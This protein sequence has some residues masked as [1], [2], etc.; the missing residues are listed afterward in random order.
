MPQGLSA[1]RFVLRDADSGDRLAARSE[2]ARTPVASL[3]KLLTALLVI[4]SPLDGD[5]EI[6]P[7]DIDLPAHF[8]PAVAGLCV[9]QSY[10][11]RDL[12][13]AMLV[14]S[15][16]DAAM[17]L[18]RAHSGSADAFAAAMTAFAQSLGMHDSRFVN[19]HGLP[20]EGQYSTAAD[21]ARLAL[22][23]DRS[24]ALRAIVR[25]PEM[26]IAHADGTATRLASTNRLLATLPGCDGMKTG[27]TR[28]SGYC[29]VASA[30][31]AA[32]RR[33]AIVLG[34]TRENVWE[35]ARLLLGC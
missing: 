15:A 5:I 35:D 19:P 29:L 1:G 28:A 7:E 33:T 3:Q 22:A 17:A 30:D 20:A 34:A 12:L 9:G 26:T 27:F 2:T 10:A 13:A 8:V 24:P 23:V 16:N 18:A 32:G 11:R 14:G 6:A 31:T 21:V 4:D 25:L